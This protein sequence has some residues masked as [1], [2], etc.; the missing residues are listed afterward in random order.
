MP[1]GRE[2][3]K[4]RANQGWAAGVKGRFSY[5]ASGQPGREGAMDRGRPWPRKN[6]PEDVRAR[7]D[8]LRQ[9]PDWGREGELVLAWPT[10]DLEAAFARTM[11]CLTGYVA[12]PV[13]VV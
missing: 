6:T 10:P 3:V 7:Q 12:I 9:I 5:W 8:R 11:E 4:I 2:V 1:L 13:S